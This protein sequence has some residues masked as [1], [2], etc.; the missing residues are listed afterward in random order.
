VYE[1]RNQRRTPVRRAIALA[2]A[3]ASVVAI[4]VTL[5]VMSAVPLGVS[6]EP[7]TSVVSRALQI[8]WTVDRWPLLVLVVLLTFV[9]LYRYSP[10][11][12]HS[13]RECLPGA[14]LAV[15]L[16][17]LLILLFRYLLELGFR[18]PT[19]VVSVDPEIILIG[20]AVAAVV[21]TGLLFY[22]ASS[23]V[24]FG[25][26]LNA[27]LIRRRQGRIGFPAPA[28]VPVTRSGPQALAPVATSLSRKLFTRRTA[29]GRPVSV[30]SPSPGRR[31]RIVSTTA[32]TAD[33]S[34]VGA[35]ESVDGGR[36]AM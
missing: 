11:V 24:L 9:C 28:R 34:D 5:A 31:V 26:E 35:E 29:N 16:W 3:L 4:T 18:A 7:D 6:G 30:P 21:A 10:D 2:Y 27:E 15:G 36:V 22:Y 13:F 20:R 17:T 32:T 8:A 19:G 1:V 12:R 14:V 33:A 25:A 23:A